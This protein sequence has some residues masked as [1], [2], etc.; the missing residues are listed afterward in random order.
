MH[1]ADDSGTT[2]NFT[3]YLH[4]A[5][6]DVWTAEPDGEWP[7]QGGE[8]AAADLG[9]VDAVTNGT[10]TIGYADAS[11]AGDLGVAEIKVGDN[12][13]EYR[14]RQRPPSS[15]P[16]ERLRGRAAA[17]RHGHRARPEGRR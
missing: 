10:G 8:A 11:K 15:T 14:R 1:R 3:D 12:F 7:F 6:P 16:P 4:E 5:A 2:E 13:V 9:V 17:E